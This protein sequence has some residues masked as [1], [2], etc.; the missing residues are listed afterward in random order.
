MFENNKNFYESP[1]IEFVNI[2]EKD[3]MVLS[4]PF[5]GEEDILTPQ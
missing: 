4:D 3:I 2:E 5:F 1:E